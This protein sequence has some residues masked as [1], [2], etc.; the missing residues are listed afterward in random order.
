MR[1]LATEVGNKRGRSV[2]R[3]VAASLVL[4]LGAAVS[5]QTLSYADEDGISFWLPGIF[6]SLAAVPQQPGFTFTVSNYFDS[7]HSEE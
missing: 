3:S 1:N 2:L 5:L 4:A 6:G 7:G